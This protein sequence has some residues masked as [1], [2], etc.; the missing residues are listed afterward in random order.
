MAVQ[1]EPDPD[2]DP[3]P[4]TAE[5]KQKAIVDLLAWK[6]SHPFYRLTEMRQNA[7]DDMSVPLSLTS[8]GTRVDEIDHRE[9]VIAEFMTTVMV[10]PNKGREVTKTAICDGRFKL[11]LLKDMPHVMYFDCRLQV[12][13]SK[14]CSHVF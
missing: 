1:S 10:C 11:T 14:Q 6:L 13:E 7:Q 9:V 2:P 4:S 3:E 8:I 5:E 12:L